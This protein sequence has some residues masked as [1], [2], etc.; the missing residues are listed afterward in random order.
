[1][2]EPLDQF[3]RSILE[4]VQRDCQL[5]AETIA[6][7]VGLSASAVQRRLKRMRETG[8]ISAEIAIVDRKIAGNPMTFITGM[9]IERENYDALSKFRVWAEK[10]DHIQQIYYVTGAVDLIAIITARDVGQYDEI[11][12]AIMSQNPQIKRIHTNVVLKEIKLGMFV[13]VEP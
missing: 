4:I 8:V 13:P 2:P 1:M 6:D 9:E 5:K 3:D 12:A 10:H 7:R 11:T